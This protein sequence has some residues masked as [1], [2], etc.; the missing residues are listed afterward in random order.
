MPNPLI[1]SLG[2][3]FKENPYSN[4]AFKHDGSEVI[5]NLPNGLQAYLVTDAEGDRVDAPP[6]WV[7]SSY[8]NELELHLS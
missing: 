4:K 3:V 6:I 5:F 1:F 7:P 2:R 8:K